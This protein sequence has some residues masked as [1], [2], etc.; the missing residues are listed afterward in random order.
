[1]L[2][3]IIKDIIYIF[4]FFFYVATNTG[5]SK[6]RQSVVISAEAKIR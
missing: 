4:C 2:L 5:H 3:S 6:F 1:M